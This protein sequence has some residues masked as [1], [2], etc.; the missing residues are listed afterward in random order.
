M[1]IRKIAAL[2]MVMVLS[3]SMIAGCGSQSSNEASTSPSAGSAVKTAANSGSD[4]SEMDHYTIGIIIHTTTDFLTSKLASY[5]A[6]IGENFNVDFE[7]YILESFADDQYLTGIENLCS[8]GVDGIIATNFSGTAILQGLKICEENGVLLGIGF[9]QVD[10]EIAEQAMK[11]KYYVGS[12]YEDD[13][14]AG[15]SL[16]ETLAAGGKKNIAAIGYEPGLLCHDRRWEGMMA[17]FEDHPEVKKV[18][19]YRGLEFTSAVENFL[20]MDPTMDGIAITL[21]GIEYC[22]EPIASA[23]RTGQVTIACVDFS[24]TSAEGLESGE[25]AITVGGQFIDSMFPFILMYNKLAG[26]PL[27]DKAVEIPVNFITCKTAAEFNDYMK[28]VHGDV[29][30]WTADELKQLVKKFNPDATIDDLINM[31]KN[32]SVEEVKTRH[33]DLFK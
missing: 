26:T 6:Y 22:R 24:D 14:N 1:K 15:Y 12:S 33:A 18:G 16:I 8:K 13:Y 3:L 30:P 32:Y 7:Y 19:E 20:A 25:L 27:S 5:M 23:G 17:A 10:S 31:G 29:F 28:Y 4:S 21:L 9:S 11:S 2:M